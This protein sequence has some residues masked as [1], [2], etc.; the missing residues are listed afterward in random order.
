MEN[1]QEENASRKQLIVRDFKDLVTWRFAR[2]LRAKV[3]SICKGFPKGE[4][5]AL[6]SQMRR[7]AISV[8][9]NIAE[10]YGRFSYQENIQ[11]C[12]QSRGSAYELRDHL[13]NAL[14]ARYTTQSEYA[15]IDAL[16]ISVTKSINGY[17]RSTRSKK[18]KA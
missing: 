11:Y 15:E 18:L 14:D 4:T 6:S 17:I 10:G 13:T 3:Y 16:A 2:N 8:S 9:A 1:G 5:F 7:E 12:R